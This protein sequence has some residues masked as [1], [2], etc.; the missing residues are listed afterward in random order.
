MTL[1]QSF[2]RLLAL[3]QTPAVTGKAPT[4][5]SADLLSA[6]SGGGGESTDSPRSGW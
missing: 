4:P 6:V 5:L 1:L 2:L 3:Q